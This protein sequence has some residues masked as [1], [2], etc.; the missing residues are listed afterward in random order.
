MSKAITI[1]NYT[2]LVKKGFIQS[3]I[4]LHSRDRDEYG[5]TKK[6]KTLS[7]QTTF[8]SEY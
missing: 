5:G 1:G 6:L 8:I 4:Y 2:T 3:I 7:N